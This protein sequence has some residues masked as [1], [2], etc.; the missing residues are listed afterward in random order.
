MSL[1]LIE[2][3]KSYQ[4]GLQNLEILKGLNLELKAGEIVA[5]LG[6]SGSGKSTLLSL[7]AGLDVPDQGVVEID[8]VS[9]SKLDSKSR[10]E[11]RGNKIGIVF[12]QFHLLSHLSALEN[13]LLPLDI[14]SSNMSIDE[15]FKKAREM[16]KNVGL[17]ERENH[18][19][20]QLSGGECQ[21]VAMARALITQP[22][23]LL[24]DEPSGNLDIKTGDKVMSLLL[25]LVRENKTTTIL[26]THSN[27][28]ARLCDRQLQLVDGIL[29]REFGG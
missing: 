27:E 26:V 7:L 8:G 13:V 14:H 17:S 16:L 12:Q 5:I 4:Q 6:P 29:K 24:A 3:K 21:R 2:I 28:L 15:K 11:F 22:S 19:P 23:I 25:K 1:K 9:L 18:F 10:T 20:S